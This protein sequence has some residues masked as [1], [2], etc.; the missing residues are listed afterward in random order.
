MMKTHSKMRW[1]LFLAGALW[2]V[3]AISACGGAAQASS[4]SDAVAPLSNV[5]A[6]AAPAMQ[7]PEVKTLYIGPKLEDCTGAGP[8]KC[9]MVKENP[10]G[11][12]QYFYQPIQGFDYEAG[13]EYEIV[14]KVEKVENPPADASSLKYT[15]VKI[16]SKTPAATAEA[17][18]ATA[19]DLEGAE[20]NLV[21]WRNDEGEMTDALNDAPIT[22]TFEDGKVAGNAGCNRYFAAYQADGDVLDI[23]DKIGSTMM[24]CPEPV[25]KQEQAYLSLLPQV[26]TFGIEGDTLTLLDS[27]G[28]ALLIFEKT[29]TVATGESEK[30][31]LIGPVWQWQRTEM[32]NDATIQ[33]DD[34]ARYTVQFNEDGSLIVK[35]DCKETSGKFSDEGGSLS[36]QLNPTT[37]QVCNDNSLADE[38]LEELSYA[39]TYLFS[40]DGNLVI[41]MQMDGGN[42]VFAPA[43]EVATAPGET[44][45]DAAAMQRLA[46]EY[47]VLLPPAEE[48]GAVRVATLILDADGTFDLSILTLGEK[49]AET[50]DGVWSVA[51]DGKIKGKITSQEGADEFQL[52][53]D[54]N[55][56]LKLEGTDLELINIDE[57][58]PLHKQLPIPVITG[59]KAYVTLDIQA[60]N[61]LD[62]F[63][64]SVNGGGSF[65]ASTLGGDCTGFVNIQPVARI[66][67]E[68][69]TDLAKIFFYSDHDPTLI[70][71]S[72]DGAFHC[73]DDASD[74]LLDPSITFEHPKDGIY[75]IWVGSYYPEQLIPGVLVVT[76]RDDVSVETF[77][78]NGLI[79]RGPVMKMSERLNARPAEALADIIKNYKQNVKRL[80]TGGKTLSVRV[81]A[82]GEAPAF[83]FD[84]EGQ[85]CNGFISEKPDLVF[86]WSGEAD[87]LSVYFEGD[88]DSTLLVVAPGGDVLCNDDAS[89]ENVNPMVI[90]PNPGQGRYAVF[91]GRVHPEDVVKGKLTVTDAADAA[92]EILAPLPAPAPDSEKQ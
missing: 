43:K 5:A 49:E 53:I 60:G 45:E 86:D 69:E 73:N 71:Q 16:V 80:K 32:A 59:Q 72:P 20:W 50:Y 26:A 36:I 11:D 37:M 88:G 58:I 35:A 6:I 83:D 63:I 52:D 92:P 67:W 17:T 62:P 18:A 70:I 31:K 78:L 23:D 40:D 61:P 90:I 10:D 82:K 57:T 19:G 34:P 1:A 4:R 13:Y 48:G 89:A 84:I 85:L 14:V 81:A 68:G 21:S 91:V 38:F 27:D 79:K 25:M 30:A 22:L 65:A 42:I 55:G 2:F 39:G 77:T 28:Q 87:A 29:P 24:M 56:D 9:M 75:N 46:G 33:V 12:Y 7:E 76:T 64:V 41:N 15:L 8:Q 51:D 54:E 44:P 74:L 66:H 47:K 3:V